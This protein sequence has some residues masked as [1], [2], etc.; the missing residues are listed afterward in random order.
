MQKQAC[1]SRL[2][3]H[4]QAH[5]VSLALADASS[6]TVPSLRVGRR[7]GGRMEAVGEQRKRAKAP[8]RSLLDGAST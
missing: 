6:D 8:S 3:A 2:A 1:G 4:V 5:T 7:A